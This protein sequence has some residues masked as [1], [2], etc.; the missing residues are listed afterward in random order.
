MAHRRSHRRRGRHRA[1]RPRWPF[2]ALGGMAVIAL[3]VP[4]AAATL[5][6]L[7]VD[8]IAAWS[9]PASVDVPSPY[10]V[11]D[12]FESYPPGTDLDGQAVDGFTWTADPGIWIVGDDGTVS[13]PRKQRFSAATVDV[14]RSDHLRIQASIENV[15]RIPNQSGP[16]LSFLAEGDQMLWV[17]Y[18]R[19][20]GRVVL[21]SYD[22]PP[23]VDTEL[24]SVAIGD[25]AAL[26]LTVEI[27]QPV[28]TVKV[29][30]ATVLTYQ[31][32]SSQLAAYGDN[33]AHGMFSERDK[34]SVFTEFFIQELG[35]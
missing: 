1:R 27:D 7:R 20:A 6:G 8:S 3:A 34:T 33:T 35:P 31:L 22:P 10:L 15:S 2:I 14:G 11:Y 28:V 5:G 4:A 26:T 18:R 19:R 13:T 29:D 32:T 16:G 9:V 23:N 12:D 24:A 25:R 30:G 17:E 21:S